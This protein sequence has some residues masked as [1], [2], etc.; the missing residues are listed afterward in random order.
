MTPPGTQSKEAEISVFKQR[1]DLLG[2]V[3]REDY[4]LARRRV[5]NNLRSKVRDDE[6]LL[7]REGRFFRRYL[8]DETI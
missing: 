1:G 6:K 4:L 3:V 2:Y 7:L 8:Y 5:V